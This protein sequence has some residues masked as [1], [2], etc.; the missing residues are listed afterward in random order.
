MSKI[1]QIAI[2][3]A[4]QHAYDQLY[5]VHMMPYDPSGGNLTKSLCFHIGLCQR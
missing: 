4:L 2:F 1:G 3:N 5:Q